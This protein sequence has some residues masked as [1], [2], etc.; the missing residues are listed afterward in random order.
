MFP[1][2][3]LATTATGNGIKLVVTFFFNRLKSDFNK[4]GALKEIVQ[5]YPAFKDIDNLLK[6]LMD[7]MQGIFFLNDNSIVEVQA[8]K[9]FVSF[10]DMHLGCY[11]EISII[12]MN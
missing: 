6:F 4:H 11:T 12:Q 10:N 3:D 1:V 9:E 8:K 7:A 2:F 5:A